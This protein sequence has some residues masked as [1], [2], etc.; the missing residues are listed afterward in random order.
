MSDAAE[1]LAWAASAE[2]KITEEDNRP[3]IVDAHAV[4]AMS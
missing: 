2:R 3:A 4:G 1:R